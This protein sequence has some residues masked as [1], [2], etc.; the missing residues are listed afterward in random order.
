MRLVCGDQPNLEQ[1]F[2]RVGR[3]LA[4]AL[5]DLKMLEPGARFLD[6]GCGCG[7]VARHL[8][9]APIAAYVGFDR[10]PGMIGWAKT[11]IGRRDERFR[12]E[13]VD[14][15]SEYEELDRQRG[16]VAAAQFEFPY[17]D[18]SF[19][20]ALAA[21]VF[22]HIDFA[23]T[24][25]YLDETARVLSAGGRLAASFFLDQTTGAFEQSGWNFVINEGELRSA[26][27]RAGLDVLHFDP[28]KPPSRH[29]WFL[30][31]SGRDAEP[32]SEATGPPPR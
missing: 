28:A 32:G 15:S 3:Q 23:A 16:A 13:H 20:A 21:S 26:L 22:T 24:S 17:E 11:W 27:E 2:E 1:H 9:H 29:S 7:R 12:F 25:H 6:I 5:E 14:V 18:D 19:T 10:H 30:L 31:Q 4:D 8:L